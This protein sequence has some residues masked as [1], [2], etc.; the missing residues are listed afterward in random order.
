MST[1]QIKA[2]GGLWSFLCRHIYLLLPVLLTFFVLAVI[3]SFALL[4][5]IGL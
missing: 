5:H 3:L 2:E 1:N 4:H